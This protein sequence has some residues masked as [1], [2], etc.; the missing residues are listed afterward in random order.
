M[1]LTVNEALQQIA[2]HDAWTEFIASKREGSGSDSVLG[3]V[4]TGDEAQEVLDSD[5]YQGDPE[6][7][8]EALTHG[9]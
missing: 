6:W 2:D 7:E 5:E 3:E 8:H 4:L 1:S 9:D